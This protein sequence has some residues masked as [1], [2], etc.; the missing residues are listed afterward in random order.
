MMMLLDGA[1]VDDDVDAIDV[2][3]VVDDVNLMIMFI[4]YEIVVLI[5]FVITI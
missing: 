3:G 1:V 4:D 2:V 5:L